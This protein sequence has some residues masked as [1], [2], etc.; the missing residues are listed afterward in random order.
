MTDQPA[1]F[2]TFYSTI[3]GGDLIPYSGIYQCIP[4]DS[5]LQHAQ[6]NVST[7]GTVFIFGVAMHSFRT[8]LGCR[9]D[10]GNGWTNTVERG[11]TLTPQDVEEQSVPITLPL[12]D[13]IAVID[14]AVS[15]TIPDSPAAISPTTVFDP[16]SIP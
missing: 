9:W 3:E 13:P 8:Q 5:Y 1:D 12:G 15:P 10:C 16:D 6:A 2:I 14:Q 11:N 7:E 4:D